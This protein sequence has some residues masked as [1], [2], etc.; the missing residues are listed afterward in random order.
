[1]F[2]DRKQPVSI[3]PWVQFFTQKGK[4]MKE[5]R[6]IIMFYDLLH[7]INSLEPFDAGMIIKSLI[8]YEIHN[9]EWNWDYSSD[10]TKK[11]IYS[12]GKAQL[13]RGKQLFEQKYGSNNE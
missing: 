13:D 10:E 3:Q 8:D 12:M 11:Y 5:K 6:S 2:L 9:K 1:V 4:R 7:L